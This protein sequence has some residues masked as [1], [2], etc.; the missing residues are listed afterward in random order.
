MSS[1]NINLTTKLFH[2]LPDEMDLWFASETALGK[3]AQQSIM[4]MN[5]IMEL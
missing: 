1:Y 3:S 4:P 2:F 5:L